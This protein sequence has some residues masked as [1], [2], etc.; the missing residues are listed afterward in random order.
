[1]KN[2]DN[3]F[4][5]SKDTEIL[6]KIKRNNKLLEIL[7]E[8]ETVT[9]KLYDPI[10]EDN[11]ADDLIYKNRDDEETEMYEFFEDIQH[12]IDRNTLF[13]LKDSNEKYNK[14]IR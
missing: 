11:L 14:L 9:R 13:L 4:S 5:V 6:I 8:L 1:M 12:F 7:S 3:R 2:I 10:H